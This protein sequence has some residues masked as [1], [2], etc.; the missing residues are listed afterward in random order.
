[1]L[2][3]PPPPPPLLSPPMRRGGCPHSLVLKV[4]RVCD[5]TSARALGCAL[6]R[7][8][9]AQPALPLQERKPC[10]EDGQGRGGRAGVPVCAVS[11]PYHATLTFPR[12]HAPCP[13]FA[14]TP[15]SPSCPS[16]FPPKSQVVA[17]RVVTRRRCRLVTRRRRRRLEPRRGAHRGR[18][19]QRGRG[20]GAA[21]GAVALN[22][23]PQ[24][25]RF[26]PSVFLCKRNLQL[27]YPV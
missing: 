24:L 6:R 21:A 23:A 27:Y 20:R 16:P 13:S 22:P 3:P 5:G 18:H 2:P 4:P 10:G 9:R 19:R 17:A 12:T 11:Q 26:S 25:P 15:C 8:R 1:V 7:S 14:D